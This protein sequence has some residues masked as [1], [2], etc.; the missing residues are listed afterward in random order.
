MHLTSIIPFS[1]NCVNEPQDFKKIKLFVI[2][3]RDLAWI[4]AFIKS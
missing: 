2:L 4:F 3:I 1:L